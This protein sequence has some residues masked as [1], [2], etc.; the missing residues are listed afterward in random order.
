MTMGQAAVN[1]A[2]ARRDLW[3]ALKELD[4]LSA[5]FSWFFMLLTRLSEPLMLLS[6]LYVIAEAGVPTIAVP[7]LHNLSVGIMICSPALILPGSF[8]VAS[9]AQEQGEHRAGLLL[10]VCW[11]VVVL[12]LVTLISLFVWHLS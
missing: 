4:F 8:V 5:F 3:H 12:T 1:Q 2:Q 7:A 11:L 10:T 6:T 9:K